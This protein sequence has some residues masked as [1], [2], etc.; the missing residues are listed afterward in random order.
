MK[1]VFIMIYPLTRKV[2]N[3]LFDLKYKEKHIQELM[4]CQK[5]IKLSK[6]VKYSDMMHVKLRIL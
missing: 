5:F 1:L 6:S 2:K 4:L 3:V